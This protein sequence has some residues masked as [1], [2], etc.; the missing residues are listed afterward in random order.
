MKSF[1]RRGL[2]GAL[3]LAAGTAAVVAPAHAQ[4]T[5]EIYVPAAPPPPRVEVIPV[6]PADRVE[7]ER[8][9]P[10]HWRWDRGEYVWVEGRYASRP[11]P[12]AEW[13]DGRWEQ[14]PR[15]WVYIE[16]HWN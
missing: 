10:G 14:R 11:S 1:T 5:A 3:T 7:I 16:G 4:L 8:W 9:R 2:F 12:R 15:G 13:I 6:I